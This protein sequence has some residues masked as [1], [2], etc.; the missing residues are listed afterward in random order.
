MYNLMESQRL[1][2]LLVAPYMPDTGSA[3]LDI[4]GCD[5]ETAHLEGQD[6]WGGLAAG[7]TIAKAK[8]LFPRIETE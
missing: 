5:P 1:I 3:V 4:L 7:A 2:A 8:P 6:A